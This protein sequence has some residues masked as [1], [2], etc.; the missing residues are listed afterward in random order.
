MKI[1]DTQILSRNVFTGSNTVTFSDTELDNIYKKYGNGSSLTATFIV[2]GSSYT[3]SKTCIITLKGNQKS[4]KSNISNSWKRGKVWINING[5][6]KRALVWI[7]INGV[8][9]RCI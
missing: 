1:G 8:W 4:I 3:N 2:S 7:N 9:R 5:T 6:W